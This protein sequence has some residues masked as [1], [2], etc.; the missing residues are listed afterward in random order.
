[1][2]GELEKLMTLGTVIVFILLVMVIGMLPIW[3][4]SR[5]L[6]YMP[7]GTFGAVLVIVFILL[8]MGRI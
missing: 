6:G 4:H 1:V 2:I 3:P 7:S 8:L 5:K